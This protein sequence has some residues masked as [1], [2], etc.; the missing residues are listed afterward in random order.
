MSKPL[1]SSSCALDLL[2]LPNEI[3]REILRFAASTSFSGEGLADDHNCNEVLVKASLG[4]LQLRLVSKQFARLCLQCIEMIDLNPDLDIGTFEKGNKFMS[5][6]DYEIRV[7]R[8]LLSQPLYLRRITNLYVFE[9]NLDEL[10]VLLR[11]CK[12]LKLLEVYVDCQ[13]P[14]GD[15]EENQFEFNLTEDMVARYLLGKLELLGAQFPLVD[16]I[17]LKVFNSHFSKN[18]GP[19]WTFSSGSYSCYFFERRRD[20]QVLMNVLKREDFSS[21]FRRCFPGLKS[22]FVN[23][24]TI[25]PESERGLCL[26][27]HF[28]VDGPATEFGS[29][30]DKYLD[31][32]IPDWPHYNLKTDLGRRE[33]RGPDDYVDDS[34]YDLDD[35]DDDDDG[36]YFFESDVSG[37]ND[38]DDN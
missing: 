11:P 36:D 20:F 3:L 6:K 14:Y 32:S 29:S 19:D 33:L 2:S 5:T 25:L 35:D 28:R 26:V 38:G 34:Y 23:D 37:D 22:L 7:I 9:R 17:N 15:T 8:L 16:F 21:S 4:V 12:K 18:E 1:S 27:E 24:M 31:A 13:Y 10:L 30:E